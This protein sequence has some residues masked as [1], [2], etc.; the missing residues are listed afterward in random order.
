M[1]LSLEADG[2]AAGVRYCLANSGVRCCG[3]TSLLRGQ[4]APPSHRRWR[5]QAGGGLL[6]AAGRRWTLEARGILRGRRCCGEVALAMPRAAGRRRS[7]S[8]L[9][10]RCCGDAGA[11]DGMGRRRK[12]DNE[13]AVCRGRAAE[14]REA[15][16]ARRWSLDGDHFLRPGVG[17]RG[18]DR[19]SVWM[20]AWR[21]SGV[22]AGT[23]ERPAG[24][25][26]G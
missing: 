17:G 15:E 9:P 18:K 26:C 25:Y 21:A 19:G 5:L 3:A 22:C 16:S 1:L 23:I 8:A 7:G 24:R 11:A 13:A 6:V 10:C 20:R 2:S 12:D 14:E 4:V